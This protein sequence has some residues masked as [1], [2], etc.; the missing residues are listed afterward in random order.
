MVLDSV[1]GKLFEKAGGLLHNEKL[2]QKGAEVSSVGLL[3]IC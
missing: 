2:E 1:A 3:W